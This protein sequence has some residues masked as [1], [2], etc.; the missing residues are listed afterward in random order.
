MNDR[1]D[2]IERAAVANLQEKSAIA[3]GIQREANVT[4]A[5]V[6]AGAGG[7][8]AIFA[9]A[10]G[11]VANVRGAALAVAVWLFL[12]A[13]VVVLKVL[14]FRDYPATYHEPKS[15]WRDDLSL[16][17]IRA[18]VLGNLESAIERAHE[19]NA[20]R[21]IWL[22]RCR[23]AAAIVTPLAAVTGWWLGG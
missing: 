4:L 23:A 18:D 2:Y 21:A 15:L 7:A 3:D 10:S 5:L 11:P 1:L 22:N 19:I 14:A 8:L 13:A 16:D 12:L 20:N 9:D 6:L 17:Q